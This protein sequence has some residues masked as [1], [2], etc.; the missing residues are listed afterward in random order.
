MC[1]RS[2][3]GGCG[4]LSPTCGDGR[5]SGVWRAGSERSSP[6][7]SPLPLELFPA[8]GSTRAFL[9][10]GRECSSRGLKLGRRRA[11]CSAPWVWGL[12]GAAAPGSLAEHP[13]EMLSGSPRASAHSPPCL[14]RIALLARVRYP[15]Q[16]QD[17]GT[18]RSRGAPAPD[19]AAAMG[20]GSASL[21]EVPWQG[22]CPR[23]PVS[24]VSPFGDVR[25]IGFS[26][27]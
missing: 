10:P 1:V 6:A 13:P 3:G 16:R 8:K 17:R 18:G 9:S 26:G 22:G 5:L 20:H 23:K 15:G 7:P 24:L 25:L 4:M 27:T 19:I 21:C 11:R 2:G 12:T 14:P